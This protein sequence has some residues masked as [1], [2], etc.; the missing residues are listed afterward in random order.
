M[1]KQALVFVFSILFFGLNVFSQTYDYLDRNQIKA[2]VN[3]H[4]TLFNYNYTPCFEVPQGL[5][6]NSIFSAN[7]WV[8]GI[9]ELGNLRAAADT[10]DQF[11][12]YYY[13]PLAEDYT[14]DAYKNKYNRV[15]KVN[16]SEIQYHVENF[17]QPGYVLP[18]SFLTWPAEGNTSNGEAAKLAPYYDYNRNGIYDPRNGDF[19]AIRGDQA[20]YFI[21][22]EANGHNYTGGL[23]LGLEIHGMLYCFNPS[24]GSALTQTV[25][26]N[27]NIFNRSNHDYSDFFAGM[28]V[29]FNL[30]SG[31]D[32]VF[33]SDSVNQMMY[34]FN[35]N[36]TEPL[37]GA[38][39][40]VQGVIMLNSEIY[41]AIQTG[42]CGLDDTIVSN[43]LHDLYSN[44]D[45]MLYGRDTLGYP[46][47]YY[48]SG[49]PETGTGWIQ[50]TA[51]N[52]SFYYSDVSGI[53]SAG[54]YN[55][56]KNESICVDL[57][58]PYARDLSGTFLTAIGLLRDKAAAIIQF[59][60]DCGYACNNN[61]AGFLSDYIE[62]VGFEIFP[63]PSYE[64]VEIN[65]SAVKT[66]NKI[67][68]VYTSDGRIINKI[69][70]NE[71]TVRLDFA[72]K[73]M[74]IIA[75]ET[76]NVLSTKKLIIM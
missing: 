7:L 73:G 41:G 25:F 2:L 1:K 3:S 10:Y 75:V 64:S 57:A 66:L 72:E 58:F 39:S 48:L 36:N 42:C 76:S 61:E 26:L 67:I 32:D 55:L 12:E 37:Y 23:N 47:T 19:P 46:T 65:L 52:G 17:D 56:A 21:F 35:A 18:E 15:W 49:Y 74:Y 20:V 8:S 60:D 34:V 13:G 31:E 43:C 33:G 38:P 40:P 27:Y 71:N 69:S 14:S 44:G 11:S 28:W 5:G 51:S 30:G 62:K 70:T 4:G 24:I 29:D 53:I 59:F 63:N 68:T 22:N 6:I 50:E 9:D 16:L 54:P 45:T